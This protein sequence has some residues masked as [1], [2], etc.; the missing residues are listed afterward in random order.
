MSDY[1]TYTLWKQSEQRL[2]HELERQRVIQER[3]ET[4]R[5]ERETEQ[6]PRE[7]PALDNVRSEAAEPADA[8]DSIDASDEL[9]LELVT[10]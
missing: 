5:N 8:V 4:Q 1:L 9:G 10:Q 2:S 6:Q 7:E 3:L